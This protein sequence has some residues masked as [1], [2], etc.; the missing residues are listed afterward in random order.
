MFVCINTCYREYESKVMSG[1]VCTLKVYFVK[2]LICRKEAKSEIVLLK[3]SY[4][5]FT[6]YLYIRTYVYCYINNSKITR[7]CLENREK[8]EKLTQKEKLCKSKL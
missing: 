4:Y 3:F 6:A 1:M 2:F 7:I 5:Y 8:F